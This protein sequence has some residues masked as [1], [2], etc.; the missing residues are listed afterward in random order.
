MKFIACLSLL[1]A[2][3]LSWAQEVDYNRIILPPEAEGIEPVERLVQ[4][5]WQNY[6]DNEIVQRQAVIAKKNVSLSKWSWLDNLTAS[7]NLNEFT[8]SPPEGTDDNFNNFFPRY[9]FGARIS[10]DIL[11]T[12]TRVRVAKEE[13]N[14]AQAEVNKQKLQIRAIV[15]RL[16]EEYK[17]AKQMYEIQSQSSEDSYTMY[18]LAEQNFR[19]GEIGVEEYTKAGELYNAEKIKLIRA[20][21]NLVLAR[22][23]IEELIGVSLSAVIDD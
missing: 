17:I 2:Y 19:E 13:L 23:N 22:V 1:L 18:T 3:T 21:S 12:P 16:H 5:A 7:G 11:N 8:I 4:L 9:N 10:L 15:Y 6:P 20:E 14:I